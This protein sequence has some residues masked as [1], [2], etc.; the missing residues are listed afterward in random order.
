LGIIVCI[1]FTFSDAHSQITQPSRYER[2]HKGRDE[3]VTIISL[4]NEGLALLQEKDKYKGT[5]RVWEIVFLDTAL[6]E[7]KLLEL[8]I[9]QRHHLVGYE[10]DK[11]HLYLLYRT[12]ETNKNSL[13]LF[14]LDTEQAT[15]YSRN[16]IKPELDFKLTH[17]C[18]VGNSMVL[19]GYVTNEPAVLLYD[20]TTANIKV[21][22]GFF[23]KDNEIVDLR[24]NQNQTF[25]VVVIDRSQR[26]ERKIIF[27]TFDASGKMLLD[28]IVLI[29]EDKSLQS[30]ISTTLEREDLLVFGSW[31]E[32]QGKQSLGFFSLA[33]DPF[34]DQKIK[35]FYFGEMNHFLDYL[36]PKRAQRIRDNTRDDLL[37]KRKP[38]FTN[39]VIPFKI[40]ENKNGF[41]MLAEV[42]NP[43]TTVNPYYNSPYSNPYYNN[44]GYYNPFWPNYYPGMRMYRP[45][46][47]GNNA[48]KNA[49][50]IRTIQSVLVAFDPQGNR[51]WDQS[52]KMDEMRKPSLEQVSDYFYDGENAFF[53]YKKESDLKVKIINTN[54]GATKE[55][56]EKIKLSDPSDEIRS[57]SE[58][59]D[60]IK[61]W[62]NNTFY[63]FGYQ[64]LR[65]AHKDQR[66]R[67]VFYI[68]KM[69]VK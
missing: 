1:L 16:E 35:Y 21:I 14:D 58:H 56:S 69:V 17:F 28:D 19:G 24:V 64:T 37:A 36:N 33:V 49:D 23:Q 57:E 15:E 65:N 29:D 9:D 31:G 12:G 51:L 66:V 61:H 10:I 67:D 22:P 55:S 47:Y 44:P 3:S 13:E 63:I 25:N 68:N 20:L 48:V 2:E 11:Q 53:I 32:K 45:Y 34:G 4:K 50:E 26:A 62:F 54:D 6:N 46:S 59:N 43:S 39:Y 38:S 7:K 52:F 18:K 5:K 8:E 41:L 30:S 42:Y 40:E 60:G 27:K